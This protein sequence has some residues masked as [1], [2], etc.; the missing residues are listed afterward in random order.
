MDEIID[1]LYLMNYWDWKYISVNEWWSQHNCYKPTT[2]SGGFIQMFDLH[3]CYKQCFWTFTFTALF[4]S[5]EKLLKIYMIEM[6]SIFI[7]KYILKI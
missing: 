6:W 7:K 4:L 3:K 5:G 1:F 2:L